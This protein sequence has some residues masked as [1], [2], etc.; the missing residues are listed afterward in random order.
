MIPILR[1]YIDP[2]RS[3]WYAQRSV[4][5]SDIQQT[6]LSIYLRLDDV[7]SYLAV[8]ILDDLDDILC[9]EIKP[10][11]IFIAKETEPPPNTLTA[12]DWLQYTLND[13]KILASQHGFAYDETPELPTT[14]AIEQAY[15]ILESSDLT[16]REFLYL[17]ED[18]YHMLWQQQYHK[19]N[20]LYLQAQQREKPMQ[21]AFQY[22][23][24]PI[25]MAYFEF[26]QRQYHAVD[27][28][29]RLT[30]RLQQLKLLNAPPIFLINH[31]EWK[32]HLIQG[33]EE[34]A[35]IQA[36]QP[37]L[38]I[39]VALEDPM[40]WLLLSY[41]KH[42]LLEYYNIH[43]KIYPIEYQA[44]DEFE[45][46]IPYRLSHR[47]GVDFAPFCRPTQTACHEM[48][49]LFYNVDE[50][51]RLSALYYILQ[52]VWTE[53]KDLSYSK[54]FHQLEQEL[55][56]Q[57]SQHNIYQQL[58]ENTQQCKA[59]KQPNLPVLVL[60]IDG[61]QYVF[62]SVYRI[63]LIERIFSHVLEQKYKADE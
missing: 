59:F 21:M 1:R 29:L 16:G 58:Q 37:E 47:M 7:Y 26:A 42:Q 56:I 6:E 57:L 55:N 30:R 62:N 45:W 22:S 48:A 3:R 54:H 8:Q 20:T 12:D 51:Q 5:Q 2:I 32:E 19:L 40:S 27:G 31:I 61:Q 63:W 9:D 13:G 43:V 44:K 60:R 14:K 34:I 28:L 46:H 25:L 36:L 41:I 17:L 49:K 18:V 33:V 15:K 52:A 50:E 35:D 10:L 38:D 24:Q 11:H 4:R 53:G 39:Y 23:Q